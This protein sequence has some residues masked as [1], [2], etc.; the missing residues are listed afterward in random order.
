MVD[1]IMRSNFTMK[2]ESKKL[3]ESPGIHLIVVIIG[4]HLIV[5]IIGIH[6]ILF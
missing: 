3:S 4:I 1:G 2:N 5:V 6:V